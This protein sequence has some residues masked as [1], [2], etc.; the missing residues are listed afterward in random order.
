M[1]APRWGGERFHGMREQ[2]GVVKKGKQTRERTNQ[3]PEWGRG[4]FGS[5]GI[6]MN[7]FSSRETDNESHPQGPACKH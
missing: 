3:L 4:R 2:W 1:R 7:P 5:G 6:N